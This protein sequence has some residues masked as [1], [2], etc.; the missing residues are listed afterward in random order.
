MALEGLSHSQSLRVIGQRLHGTGINA[1]ELNKKGDEYIVRIDPS[2]VVGKL[3]TGKIVPDGISQNIFGDYARA[4]PLS[5]KFTTAEIL[6]Y[7]DEERLRRIKPSALPDIG[8]LSVVLRV[9]GDY[10]D[11]N[12]AD[13]FAILWSKYSVKVWYGDKEQI[14]TAQSLY[15]LGIVM[16]LRSSNHVPAKRLPPGRGN[17]TRWVTRDRRQEHSVSLQDRTV[18][19]GIIFAEKGDQ[20]YFQRCSKVKRDKL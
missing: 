18:L 7:D 19:P 5:L 11:R 20:P 6:W 3:S 16:Y 17:A 4:V 8:H 12:A 14:F 15:D 1:F 9:L 10:L 13:D 2:S